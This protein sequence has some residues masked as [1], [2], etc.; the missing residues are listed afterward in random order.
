MKLT[1]VERLEFYAGVRVRQA[2]RRTK[3]R[4][5]PARTRILERLRSQKKSSCLFINRFFT[6][7]P[8]VFHTGVR[9]GRHDAVN[10]VDQ[11]A[12]EHRLT[13]PAAHTT[14]EFQ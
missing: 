5:Q 1:V 6:E 13:A 3:A 9:P 12:V 4:P 11:V 2:K 10:P 7:H 14:L 8:Q